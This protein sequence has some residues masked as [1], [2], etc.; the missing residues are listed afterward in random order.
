[1]ARALT[2]RHIPSISAF[3]DNAEAGVLISYGI[4]LIG[5]FRDLAD[6]VDRIAKGG[7]PADMPVEQSTRFHMTVNLK[8]A[9]ALGL[10]LPITFT[11][12]AHE[13]FE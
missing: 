12:R 6:Y 9:A 5:L 11:A 7:K 2:E 8:T 3:R 13:V 1:M 4:D 10:S